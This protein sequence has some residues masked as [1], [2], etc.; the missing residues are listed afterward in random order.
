MKIFLSPFLICLLF[1]CGCTVNRPSIEEATAEGAQQL[2]KQNIKEL[3]SSNELQMVS[4]DKSVEAMIQFNRGG[5]LT[6]KN[7]LGEATHGRWSTTDNN[8]LC[9]QFRFWDDNVQSC[10][11]VYKSGDQFLLYR[12]G[13]L[14]NRLISSEEVLGSLPD[15]NSGVMG[16][17]P[18]Q[19]SYSTPAK[20]DPPKVAAGEEEVS[21]LSTLTFGLL[22][23]DDDEKNAEIPFKE[24][25][26]VEPM[27][28]E[29]QL[30][31]SQ[32]QLID[33]G[34]CP[35]C[36]LQN[37]DLKGLKL[38]GANLAGANLEGANL[39]EVNLKG[40]NLR[41]A[42]LV[43]TR[44]T[45]AILIKADLQGANLSDANIHWADLTKADLRGANL[46]R[47]YM[48]KAIFYK[49][50]LTGADFSGAQTQRTIFEKAAG[51]PDHILNRGKS[52]DTDPLQ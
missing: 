14:E 42:N 41:G 30:S 20:I 37:L 33:T 46:T 7:N 5:K 10:Y 47:C 12:S 13:M 51:V 48:V 21:L 8:R 22:G 17:P 25:Y 19:S 1:L 26:V 18:Q 43:S 24:S 15:I 34:D 44:L 29:V 3:L 16:S 4:W 23:D 2:S 50:D 27:T 31:A 32:Q 35:G 38:S 11:L 9:L 28:P 52:E 45:D 39:Q 36:D 6:G 49:A 40:A